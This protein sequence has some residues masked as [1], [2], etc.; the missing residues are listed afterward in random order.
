MRLQKEEHDINMKTSLNQLENSL[1]S[2]AAATAVQ[3][4][5]AASNKLREVIETERH[6]AKTDYETAQKTADAKINDL[7]VKLKLIES[8]LVYS[9][10][11][12]VC[13]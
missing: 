1:K 2:E 9:S 13:I 5:T 7:Q 4:S 11:V 8:R 6:Q 12:S 3:A 10:Y